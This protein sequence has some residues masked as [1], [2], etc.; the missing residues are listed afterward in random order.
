MKN[1]SLFLPLKTLVSC[2]RKARVDAKIQLC[3]K[4]LDKVHA[5]ITGRQRHQEV[6]FKRKW[7]H[8]WEL[9][10]E[11]LTIQVK[12]N[13]RQNKKWRKQR[14]VLW[15][16]C[17]ESVVHRGMC[18]H[19]LHLK[20]KMLQYLK[21]VSANMRPECIIPYCEILFH[22]QNYLKYYLK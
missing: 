8:R 22:E 4:Q 5:Y 17:Q 18:K 12:N 19:I 10:Y 20:C 7:H 11:A 9:K 15:T 21:V 3:A 14:R 2:E 16:C 13:R 6:V 1:Q